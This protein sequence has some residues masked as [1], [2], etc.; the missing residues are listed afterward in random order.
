MPTTVTRPIIVKSGD[1]ENPGILH[2]KAFDARERRIRAAKIWG[3]MWLGAVLSVPIIIAHFLLVPGFLI[4]GPVIAMRRYRVSEVPD[5]VSG[6]CPA[7]NEQFSLALEAS[8][9]LPLWVHCPRCQASLH[10]REQPQSLGVR[11]AVPAAE[12]PL[13]LRDEERPSA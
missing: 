12:A 10:L 11:Q 3:M 9:R 2:L 6:I 1:H 13:A 8:A 5:E 4:A 7:N